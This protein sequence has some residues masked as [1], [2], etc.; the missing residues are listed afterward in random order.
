VEVAAAYCEEVFNY[1][2]SYFTQERLALYPYSCWKETVDLTFESSSSKPYQH[3]LDKLFGSQ[4]FESQ[5]AS[6]DKAIKNQ[7]AKG[8]MVR[9]RDAA[10]DVQSTIDRYLRGIDAVWRPKGREQG[11]ERDVVVGTLIVLQDRLLKDVNLIVLEQFADP[12][13]RHAIDEDDD[14]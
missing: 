8:G 11:L 10:W 2:A 4:N 12:S 1:A 5:L 9:V 6:L 13:R 3:D 7:K 14:G